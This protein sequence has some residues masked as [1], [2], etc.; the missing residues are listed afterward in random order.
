MKEKEAEKK[1]PDLAQILREMEDEL[2]RDVSKVTAER[3]SFEEAE[4]QREEAQRAAELSADTA[5]KIGAAASKCKKEQQS[6]QEDDRLNKIR[7]RRRTRD[8]EQQAMDLL[9]GTLES[10][11]KA[12]DSNGDGSLGR[13]EVEAAFKKSDALQISDES[14]LPVLEDILGNNG[15]RASFE[16]FKEIAWRASVKS[17]VPAESPLR[18]P[19]R[20]AALLR[21]KHQPFVG[22]IAPLSGARAAAG[23][24]VARFNSGRAHG[25]DGSSSRGI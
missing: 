12:A 17:A 23:V 7:A 19:A 18:A 4:K 6:M 2:A 11:F 8:L 5:A 3:S 13:D 22:I 21:P 24:A 10:V 14:L 25:R 15:G 9:N 16:Q 20:G 1:E